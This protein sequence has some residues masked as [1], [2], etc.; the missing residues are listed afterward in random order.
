MADIIRHI[1]TYIRVHCFAMCLSVV[2]LSFVALH[3]KYKKGIVA[4]N[5]ELSLS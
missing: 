2:L 5:H 1:P 3:T 4:L